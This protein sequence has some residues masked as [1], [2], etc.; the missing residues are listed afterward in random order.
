MTGNY[1]GVIASTAKQSVVHRK[2]TVDIISN[3]RLLRYH[4]IMIHNAGTVPSIIKI[5]KRDGRKQRSL[6]MTS[7]PGSQLISVA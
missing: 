3:N 2:V 1:S 5:M 4:L 7:F 6:A